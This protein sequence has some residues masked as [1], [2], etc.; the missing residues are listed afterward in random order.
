MLKKLRADGWWVKRQKGSHR[1]L[2]HPTKRG[3]VTVP[4][5]PSADLDRKTEASILRQAQLD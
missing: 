2:E 4:G 5:K 3:T 1:Q